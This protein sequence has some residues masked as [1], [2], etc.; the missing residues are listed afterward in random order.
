MNATQGERIVPDH[1]RPDQV[2][3]FDVYFDAGLLKDVHDGYK[4]LHTAAPDIFYTS[5]NGGHWI[6]TRYDDQVRIL[7]DS[8]HFSNR[9]LD[10]PKS[11]SPN[12]MIPLNLDPPDHVRYRALLLKYFGPKAIRD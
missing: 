12:V 3:D 8:E 4:R 11:N 1:V 5:L 2:F 7:K 9:E 10:I 6:V